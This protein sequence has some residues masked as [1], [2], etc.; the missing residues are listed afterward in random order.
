VLLT[1]KDGLA[2]WFRAIAAATNRTKAVEPS[3]DG[4]PART[5]L[6]QERP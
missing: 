1:S 6:S 5:V 2:G 4:P 3:R